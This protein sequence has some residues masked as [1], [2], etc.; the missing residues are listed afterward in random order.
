VDTARDLKLSPFHDKGGPVK[1]YQAFGE[2]LEGLLEEL[3]WEL[4][5]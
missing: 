5:A 4:V 2:E 1:A 3:N